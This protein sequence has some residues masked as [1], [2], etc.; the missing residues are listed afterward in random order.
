MMDKLYKLWGNNKLPVLWV[1]TFC[2]SLSGASMAA[3]IADSHSS[4][5]A[6]V[7]VWGWLVTEGFVKV[8]QLVNY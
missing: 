7:G 8:D 2:S 1:I 3:Q 4:D 5:S 6:A